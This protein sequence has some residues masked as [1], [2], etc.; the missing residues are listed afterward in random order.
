[1]EFFLNSTKFDK[2]A[3]IDKNF[4]RRLIKEEGTELKNLITVKIS[5]SNEYKVFSGLEYLLNLRIFFL[6]MVP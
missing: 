1:M 4:K 2:K 6:E 3:S 5:S